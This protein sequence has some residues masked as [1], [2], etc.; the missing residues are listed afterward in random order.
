MSDDHPPHD[1]LSQFRIYGGALARQ[2]TES[3][4]RAVERQLMGLD[5]SVPEGFQLAESFTLLD[6]RRGDIDLRMTS[7]TPDDPAW[8]EMWQELESVLEQLREVVSKMAK[9]P[10]ADLLELRAKATILASLLRP[11]DDGGGAIARERERVA[12]ALA[13]TDDIARLPDR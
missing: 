11:G 3:Q 10:A 13:L 4:A 8:N 7:L 9:S 12:L 1:D 2:I 6:A 5:E